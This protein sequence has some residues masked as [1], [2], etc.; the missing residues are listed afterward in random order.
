MNNTPWTAHLRAHGQSFVTD[1]RNTVIAKGI[2]NPD[3]A[4]MFAA[5]PE[6]LV[7]LR[8]AE[9]TLIDAAE[10]DELN[11]CTAEDSRWIS[12]HNHVTAAIAKTADRE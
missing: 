6:M 3:H 11:G 7:A 8:D 5:A 1:A 9:A 4:T 10:A 2:K 12:T